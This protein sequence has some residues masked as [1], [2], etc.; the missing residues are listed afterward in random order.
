M[1]AHGELKP[2]FIIMANEVEL[3]ELVSV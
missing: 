2:M 1:A 3:L